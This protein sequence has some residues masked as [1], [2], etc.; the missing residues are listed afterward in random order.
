MPA[1]KGQNQLLDAYTFNLE[2]SQF[3]ILIKI[4]INKIK[5]YLLYKASNILVNI[6]LYTY[7]RI[8]FKSIKNF[9]TI[10]R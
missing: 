2:K 5:K 9:N 3:P 4:K 8:L 6:Y 10:R 7:L 1:P